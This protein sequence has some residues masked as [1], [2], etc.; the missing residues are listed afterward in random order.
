MSESVTVRPA[1]PA[2]APGIARV[3]VETW[4]NAYSG[5][6]PTNYLVGMNETRQAVQWEAVIRR[7]RPPGVVLVAEMSS[8][9]GRQVI[10]LGNCG[11][12]RRGSH[13]GEVYTL[14]VANDYQGLGMGRRLL[15]GL[16][17]AL[18]GGDLDDA[19]VWVLSGNPA[20]FFYEAMGGA[21]VATRREPFAGEILDEIAYA[22]PDL[23]AWLA[24]Y[25]GREK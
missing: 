21:P 20:R 5:V 17:A 11:R 16:F 15:R 25:A 23:S 7:T 14:Y 19:L 22:W 8:V 2:D 24:E 13:A 10:G 4:R 18:A 1:R 9:Y 3:Y 12:A 6:L